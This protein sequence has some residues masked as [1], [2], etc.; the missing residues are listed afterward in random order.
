MKTQARIKKESP[1]YQDLE[2]MTQTID[3][4]RKKIELIEQ[5]TKDLSI[6]AKNHTNCIILLADELDMTNVVQGEA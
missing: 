3:G 6:Q 2:F 1:S 5:Q 4:L